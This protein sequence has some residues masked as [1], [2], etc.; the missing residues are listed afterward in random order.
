MQGWVRIKFREVLRFRMEVKDR[1]K[2]K[3]QMIQGQEGIKRGSRPRHIHST[4]SR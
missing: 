2:V 4:L 3:T 1:V